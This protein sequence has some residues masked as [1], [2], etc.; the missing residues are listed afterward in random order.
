MQDYEKKEPCTYMIQI[1][2]AV[3]EYHIEVTGHLST[4]EFRHQETIL[5]PG[6]VYSPPNTNKSDKLE[7][8]VSRWISCSNEFF[9]LS[10]RKLRC[11]HVVG[12]VI[13]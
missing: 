1:I 9:H 5:P 6:K 8:S 12:E 3:Y 11:E 2:I 7:Y 10:V 13:W 4:R